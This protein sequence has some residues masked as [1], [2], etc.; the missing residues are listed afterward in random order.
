MAWLRDSVAFSL[1][2]FLGIVPH[3]FVWVLKKAG[4]EQEAA[5]KST[6][7]AFTVVAVDDSDFL[8]RFEEVGEHDFANFEELLK[9]GC[10]VILPKEGDNVGEH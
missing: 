8:G 2:S 3:G 6:S 9:L 7:P 4:V 5:D 10:F 1:K